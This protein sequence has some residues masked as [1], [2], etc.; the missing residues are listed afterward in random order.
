[1]NIPADSIVGA[2]DGSFKLIK[3]TGGLA[4]QVPWS[5]KL[6]RERKNEGRCVSFWDFD[7]KQYEE[8]RSK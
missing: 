5:L 3:G 6:G 4:C 8:S 2:G 7:T 1:M